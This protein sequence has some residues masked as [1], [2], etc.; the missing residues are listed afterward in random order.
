MLG[1]YGHLMA[2]NDSYSLFIVAASLILASST[3]PALS[4]ETQ[5]PLTPE[6]TLH[7][8]IDYLTTSAEVEKT[9]D[10]FK[11]ER[12]LRE[13]IELIETPLGQQHLEG[14][15]VLAWQQ[16][17][18]LYEGRRDWLEAEEI[19][20]NHGTQIWKPRQLD[21]RLAQLFMSEGKFTYAR[22]ILRT[23]FPREK[24]PTPGGCCRNPEYEHK[25]NMLKACELK[26]RY[27]TE[28]EL[29]QAEKKMLS[30]IKGYDL[31]FEPARRDYTVHS[32]SVRQLLNF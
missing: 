31:D 25:A 16:L 5:N 27:V 18:F 32:K 10:H 6:E 8:R 24:R 2:I 20:K 12:H 13:A 21:Y 1:S 7:A 11:A 26:T 28:E 14:R 17:L 22:V 23:I 30:E 3:L 15:G 4:V 9:T 19:Y 29:Q